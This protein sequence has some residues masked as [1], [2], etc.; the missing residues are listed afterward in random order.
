MK[1]KK[2]ILLLSI[3]LTVTGCKGSKITINEAKDLVDNIS[4]ASIDEYKSDKLSFTYEYEY[5]VEGNTMLQ[6][7]INYDGI[8]DNL[9]I[10]GVV[11][12]DEEY[13]FYCGFIEGNYYYLDVISKE[14]IRIDGEV[15]I[16]AYYLNHSDQIM[17]P[18]ITCS[19][20]L[21]KLNNFIEKND[22]NCTYYSSGDGNLYMEYSNDRT[23]NEYKCKIKNNKLVSINY[24]GLN[25]EK[26]QIE[27]NTKIK[28]RANVKFPSLEE[29]DLR[30]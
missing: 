15:G 21:A 18:A 30:K 27:S 29:Y 17:K 5:I 28:Y 25:D 24:S 23:T 1:N 12:S 2:N 20:V 16:A 6:E 8:T 9:H 22:Y 26:K 4:I 10:K 19:D 13:E 14:Y 3:L 7:C 11:D